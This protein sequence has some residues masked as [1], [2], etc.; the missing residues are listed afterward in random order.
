MQIAVRSKGFSR[1][2]IW[3]LQALVSSKVSEKF[4]FP[5]HNNGA[6]RM[7]TFAEGR[8]ELTEFRL[9]LTTQGGGGLKLLCSSTNYSCSINENQNRYQ[10]QN[11]N[12]L[13]V[14]Q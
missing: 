10:N 7:W 6:A 11:Q 5:L 2:L 13:N 8:Y 4:V 3:S 9:F 12:V 1:G 14:D